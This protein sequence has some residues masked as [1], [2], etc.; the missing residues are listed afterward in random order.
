M[1]A[2]SKQCLYD[3]WQAHSVPRTTSWSTWKITKIV[4]SE[5]KKREKPFIMF[6][7]GLRW[8]IVE[9]TE[10]ASEHKKTPATWKRNTPVASPLS[11]RL[12][13]RA[14]R[15][16][17]AG[18]FHAL[19]RVAC[20]ACSDFPLTKRETGRSLP[21]RVPNGLVFDNVY[22]ERLIKFRNYD[23]GRKRF[24]C[25]DCMTWALVPNQ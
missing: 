13:M 6:D 21:R 19:S 9:R 3:E 20:L 4:W 24:S 18:D 8:G 12:I 16:H 14:T 5:R 2:T 23:R 7:E 17:E 15:F 11:L 10:D 22:F 1:E 25:F